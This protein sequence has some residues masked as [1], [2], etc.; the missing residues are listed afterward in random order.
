M[1]MRSTNCMQLDWKAHTSTQ[2]MTQELH[3]SRPLDSKLASRSTI[4]V[5]LLCGEARGNFERWS[6]LTQGYYGSLENLR[7]CVAFTILELLYACIFSLA[8]CSK[9]KQRLGGSINTELCL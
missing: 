6:V 1:L 2:T 3:E 7:A 9:H 5:E 4:A 8:L